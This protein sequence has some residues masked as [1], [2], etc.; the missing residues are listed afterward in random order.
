MTLISY[1]ETPIQEIRDALLE[2]AGIRLL[3]KREDLNNPEVSGNKWWKL[4]HNLFRAHELGHHTLLTFGGA[5]SNHLYAL[6]AAAHALKVKSIGIVRGEQT[7]PLNRTLDFATRKGMKLHYLSREQYREKSDEKILTEMRNRFGEFYLIPEGGTNEEAIKG[8]FELGEKL[9]REIQFDTLCLAVGTGGTLAGVVQALQP[10]QEVI[11]VSVLKDGRFLADEVRKWLPE[12]VPG[13][14]R[15]ETRFDF[16]GYAKTTPELMNFLK[17]QQSSHQ[18]PLD[19][20]YTAKA[21]FA[22]YS[23]IEKGKFRRGST[24]LMLH[25]GGLQGAA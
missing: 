16:G 10:N 11:G 21:L 22:V 24:V 20:V 14:W 9:M 2:K 7:L 6:A 8:C 13:R 19:Q 25:T 17:R 15:I 3:I 4:K 1:T 5:Y 18:L 12:R 23:M